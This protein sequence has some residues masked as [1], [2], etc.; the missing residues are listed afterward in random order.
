MTRT[1]NEVIRSNADQFIARRI[2]KSSNMSFWL[3][4]NGGKVSISRAEY[5]RLK[6]QG[7]VTA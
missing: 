5:M 7:V 6:A 3:F 1:L 2:E 4:R